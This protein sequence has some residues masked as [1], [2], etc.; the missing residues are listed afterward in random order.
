MNDYIRLAQMTCQNDILQY[1]FE[2]SLGVFRKKE[3]FIEY[4]KK[5]ENPVESV[6]AMPFAAIMAPVA[7]ATGADLVLPS[8]DA[9]FARTLEAGSNY[10]RKCYP[11]WPFRGKLS[12]RLVRNERGPLSR[13]GMLYSSGLDSLT[14]Y[15]HH[16][17]EKP[18]LFTVIGADFPHAQVSFASLCKERLFEQLARAEGLDLT[19]I[20]TDISDIL[21]LK[22]LEPYATNWY[23]AVQH[24][25]MLTSLVAPLTHSYLKTL[26]IASC[27]HKP[28]YDFPCGSE[29]EVVRHLAWSGTRVADDL[30]ELNRAQKISRYLKGREEFYRYL[31]VC[32]IQYEK[33]NCSRCEKCLRTI[34]ELLLNN[35]DPN[36]L[37]FQVT[38]ATLSRLKERIARHYHVFFRGNEGV[39][40]FWRAIQ[41]SIDLDSLEDLY[42]SREFFEWFAGFGRIRRRNRPAA[43]RALKLLLELRDAGSRVK[44]AARSSR[45]GRILLTGSELNGV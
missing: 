18:E 42:G 34:C 35:L 8:L 43:R 19:Y 11:R 29:P 6:N 16:R 30:H 44:T 21:D 23:G 1:R 40:N 33:I 41:E 17:D 24:G 31:R 38:R 28:D 26:Y 22:R 3:F 36:R 2:T 12:A 4:R 10:W 14:T 13:T 9:E 20:H 45:V 39:L 7:W 25:L 37:N 15:L 32:W 5:I 27:S